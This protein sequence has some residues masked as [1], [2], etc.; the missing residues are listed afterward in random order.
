MKELKSFA[1]FVLRSIGRLTWLR[2]LWLAGARWMLCNVTLPRRWRNFVL[3]EMATHI[4]SYDYAESVN[5][6]TGLRLTVGIEDSVSRSILLCSWWRDYIWEPQTLRL[7]LMLQSGGVTIVAGGH[8]G[9]DALHLARALQTIGGR[10]IAFEPFSESYERFLRNQH[11]SNI[12]NVTLERIALSDH[13]RAEV[14]LHVASS[15]SSI[16][17]AGVSPD[18]RFEKV[19]A[20]SLD[21]YAKAHSL[22]M[23]EL[24]FLDVEGSELKVL[25]GATSL[26]KFSP[27]IIMEIN[28]PNIRD[29][30]FT[31]DDVYQ[32]LFAQNYLLYFIVDD[33]FFD[34][35]D[36]YHAEVVL[37]P[38]FGDDPNFQS[39]LTIFN[40]LA[41]R[42]PRI[43]RQSG[44]KIMV[45]QPIGYKG[46]Q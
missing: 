36:Y 15:N 39:R 21:D 11:D 25:Q 33:Y 44:I 45:N 28:R 41:V 35:H 32:F 46:T 10:V 1:K 18:E 20:V 40:V 37:Y 30:G 13:S 12:Y 14:V 5:L 7:A 2:D 3:W 23:V 8:I 29:L 6:F 24:I 34:L 4:L 26:L 19:S 16:D 27:I 17:V 42:D 43:L 9:Y 31:P 22:E 38:L